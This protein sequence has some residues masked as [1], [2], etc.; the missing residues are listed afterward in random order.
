MVRSLVNL[1]GC[2]QMSYHHS[3][4]HHHEQCACPFYQPHNKPF[5]CF[6]L[7]TKTCTCAS[8][9]SWQQDSRASSTDALKS[10]HATNNWGNYIPWIQ[11]LHIESLSVSSSSEMRIKSDIL[12][13]MS[14]PPLCKLGNK[15]T[16]QKSTDTPKLPGTFNTKKNETSCMMELA[17]VV[18]PLHSFC[19]FHLCG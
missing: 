19:F 11:L 5:A 15:D 10:K 12:R 6:F 9:F 18:T 2:H 14:W 1:H 16:M 17:W 3:Q 7:K 4:P 8:Q 13:S